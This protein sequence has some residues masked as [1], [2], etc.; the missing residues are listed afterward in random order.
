[1]DFGYEELAHEG[2]SHVPVFTLRAWASSGSESLS[3]IFGSS[4]SAGNKKEAQRQA[5]MALLL[6]LESAEI[7]EA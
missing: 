6:E 1:L 2:L 3:K 7:R 4:V 5:A